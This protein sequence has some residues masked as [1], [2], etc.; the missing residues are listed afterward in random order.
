MED[1]IPD[2]NSLSD[3]NNDTEEKEDEVSE[4]LLKK[5]REEENKKTGKKKKKPKSSFRQQLLE[6]QQ[7]QL[8]SFQD[9]ELRTQ[10]MMLKF[11][12]EQIESRTCLNV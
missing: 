8:R 6:L 4:N 2:D 12:E 1:N 11:F 3:K 10:E 9:S 5:A 7:N